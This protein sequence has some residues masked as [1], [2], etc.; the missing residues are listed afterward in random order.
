[1]DERRQLPRW[2]IKKEVKVRIPLMR[3]R[4]LNA[5][6]DDVSLPGIGRWQTMFQKILQRINQWRR[7]PFY[8]PPSGWIYVPSI[9]NSAPANPIINS[10]ISPSFRISDVP[11]AAKKISDKLA[12]RLAK[13]FRLLSFQNVAT[14]ITIPPFLSAVKDRLRQGGMAL[15]NVFNGENEEGGASLLKYHRPCILSRTEQ[16]RTEQN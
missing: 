5:L 10:A 7:R 3:F 8:F 2:E 6:N 14:N 16:N 15:L 13:Y 9:I 1:M 12:R 4:L 11:N